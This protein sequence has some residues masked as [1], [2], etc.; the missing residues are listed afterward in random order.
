M[1]GMKRADNLLFALFAYR[2][3]MLTRDQLIAIIGS[4]RHGKDIDLGLSLAKRGLIDERQAEAVWN[5]V[6]IQS[7]VHG[8]AKKALGTVEA[9]VQI[10]QAILEAIKPQPA[11]KQS[12]DDPPTIRFK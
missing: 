7:D 3:G 8:G 5:L 10:Q 12:S 1:A 4:L 2:V 11:S 6:D 9:G